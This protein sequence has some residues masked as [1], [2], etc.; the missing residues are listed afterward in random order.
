MELSYGSVKKRA[1]LLF[2][3]G[4]IGAA[5]I[6]YSYSV[7]GYRPLAKYPPDWTVFGLIKIVAL[8]LAT[9]LTYWALRPLR[10]LERSMNWSA[11]P[12]GALGVGVLILLASA[13]AVLFW[14]EQISGYV[15]EEKVLSILTE[16]ML[17]GSL[18]Y[19][20]KS[21]IVARTSN[22]K[23]LFG[24]RPV[25]VIGLMFAAVL[26]ILLEEMSYGQHWL[27]FSTPEGFEANQQNETNLHNFYTHRFEAAY[28]S[29]AVLAFV[30][31]PFAWPKKVPELLAGLSVYV[32][33]PAF[34]IIALPLCGMMFETWNYVPYQFLFYFG[35]FVAAHFYLRDRSAD[36]RLRIAIMVAAM[37]LSQYVFLFFGHT[38]LDGHELTEIREFA[39]S[40]ALLAYGYVI[41]V[42]FRSSAPSHHIA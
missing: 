15:R 37:L 14:P 10:K 18:F 34:A 31:L 42:R 35:L 17:L 29:A 5:F 40:M 36:G 39:I 16:V 33:S 6:A 11:L 25:V 41:W 24:L 2:I 32:P 21:A 38:M 13:V 1:A 7:Y 22:H 3:S 9:T 8:V 26:F 4:I 28:Y 23:S 27:G 30:A 20:G 12:P 19:L